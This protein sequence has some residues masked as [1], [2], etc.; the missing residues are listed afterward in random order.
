M[1][2]FRV[3]NE[4]E[5]QLGHPHFGFEL[6]SHDSGKYSIA[7]YIVLK[8]ATV[9]DAAHNAIRYYQLISNCSEQSLIENEEEAQF[10]TRY[11][12]MGCNIPNAMIDGGLVSGYLMLKNTF[13][14]SS[15]TQSKSVH[16]SI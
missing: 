13:Q 14:N 6:A 3:Y 7:G 2:L 5:K 9:R 12:D 15:K 11:F 10:I 16:I 1:L 4:I 8:S